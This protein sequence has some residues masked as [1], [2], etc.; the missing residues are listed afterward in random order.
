MC[1]RHTA[2]CISSRLHLHALRFHP[3]AQSFKRKQND[4]KEASNGF[5]IVI[6][7]FL[8]PLMSALEFSSKLRRLGQ[9]RPSRV[10][11]GSMA[12]IESSQL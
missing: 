12:L 3:K 5:T 1:S 4:V 10:T 6:T 11:T 7:S 2:T 9:Y 8:T